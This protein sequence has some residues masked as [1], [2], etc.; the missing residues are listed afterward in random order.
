MSKP[1]RLDHTVCLRLSAK[2]IERSDEL[3]GE[4]AHLSFTRQSLIRSALRVGLEAIECDPTVLFQ[5]D[6]VRTK[7]PT[8]K[9]ASRRK[10]GTMG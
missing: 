9:K 4:L 5:R 8:R 7:A 1:D 10:G 2:D 3:V 6:S